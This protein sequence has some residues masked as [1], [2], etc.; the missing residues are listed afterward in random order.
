MN[1]TRPSPLDSPWLELAVGL[2]LLAAGFA[3]LRE[4]IARHMPNQGPML[5]HAA[6]T[7]GLAMALRSLPGI[8]LGLELADKAVAG[9]SA[10]PALAWL[11]ALAHCRAADLAMGVILMAAGLADLGDLAASGL[12]AL[13]S[14][15]GAA[16]FGAAP[17]LDALLALVK[18]AGRVGSE[19]PGLGLLRRA[20]ANPWVRAG[21]GLAL[22]AG[23]LW[24]LWTAWSANLAGHR[25]ALPGALSALGLFGLVTGLPGVYL[26]LRALA[27][28]QAPRT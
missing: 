3:E 16:L 8:F 9:L 14:A 4:I 21:A 15:S 22:L 5:P 11:D 24:E 2:I 12:P 18:G 19:V 13:N 7:V 23:G 20:T 6:A 10:R 1:P 28:A 27:G 25:P 17:L 26:G